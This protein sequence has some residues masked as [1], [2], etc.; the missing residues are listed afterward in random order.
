MAKELNLILIFACI[1][2]ALGMLL[3]SAFSYDLNA[4]VFTSAPLSKVSLIQDKELTL[5]YA[6]E[7][8]EAGTLEK[9]FTNISQ[10]VKIEKIA[11]VGDVNFKIL[12]CADETR[13]LSKCIQFSK[14]NKTCEKT[15]EKSYVVESCAALSDKSAFGL[16]SGERIKIIPDLATAKYQKTL[17]CPSGCYSVFERLYVNGVLIEGA[18]WWSGISMTKYLET[19]TVANG[20]IYTDAYL[21]NQTI[22]GNTFSGNFSLGFLTYFEGS[23]AGGATGYI[24]AVLRYA[25]GTTIITSN[26]NDYTDTGNLERN[27]TFNN[28]VSITTNENYKI[29]VYSSDSTFAIKADT[30]GS[31]FYAGGEAQRG[32]GDWPNNYDVR[33]QVWG[34]V[35]DTTAPAVVFHSAVPADLDSLNGIAGLNLTYN[36]SDAGGINDSS[37]NLTFKSNSSLSDVLSYR[38]GTA[39]LSGWQ[40]LKTHTN[41][42]GQYLFQLGDNQIYPHTEQLSSNWIRSAAHSSVSF[43]GTADYVKMRLFNVSNSSQ[44]GFFELM[45]SNSSATVGSLPFFYCNSSYVSGA[46]SSSAN[47]VS[48]Y[49]LPRTQGYNHSHN[50]SQHVIV[51]FPINATSGTVGGVKVSDVSYFLIRGTAP[52]G[53]NYY[54]VNNFSRTD[55]TQTTGNGGNTWA[56]ETFSLDMHL[57]QYSS[58]YTFYS[59]ACASDVSGNSNCTSARS[60][61]I[62]LGGLPPSA[63]VVYSP[64]TAYYGSGMIINY[65]ASFSPNGYAISYYNISLTD[66]NQTFVST[67]ISNNSDALGYAWTIGATPNGQYIISVRAYDSLGQNSAG[68]SESFTI[69]NVSPVATLG[70][71]PYAGFISNSS[72]VLFDVKGSDNIGLALISV[73]GNWTGA[74]GF[75]ETN[76]T[77]FNNSWW[78][79]TLTGLPDGRWGV[80]AF[81][82]ADNGGTGTSGAYRQFVIDTTA[83]YFLQC[84][85]TG[86]YARNST[87][88]LNLTAFDNIELNTTWIMSNSSGSW[89]IYAM[90]STPFNASLWP[91][92]VSPSAGFIYQFWANDSAG[93]TN[94]S[95]NCSYEIGVVTT[96]IPVTTTTCN[97]TTNGT[98]CCGDC[99]ESGGALWLIFILIFFAV[100]FYVGGKKG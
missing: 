73:F 41:A 65:T 92:S 58:N 44:Y 25:N 45:V 42:S 67:I 94:S 99:S 22:A 39:D 27:F 93:N 80:K 62:G 3:G 1:S 96:T 76:S 40:T 95:A 21:A 63:P 91:V 85:G 34:Y 60:D 19:F 16:K 70:N 7:K 55:D 56:G 89:D 82:T 2:V 69:D 6:P 50:L 77:P 48:F 81:A 36:I 52:Q 97:A 46:V 47:C 13:S 14:D 11:Y 59:Y 23:A 83:P 51:P 29:T 20:Q 72:T 37:V 90:N 26:P 10:L 5:T 61:L 68:Y 57:H 31:N 9:N 35:A 66:L 18:T 54:T 86:V 74:G 79:A 24:Y 17:S 12:K 38:N 33:F 75:G 64:V 32:E 98:C 4:S 28:T 78:N 30:S 84:N 53:W 87:I 43:G 88:F 71:A 100:I 15:D 49:N 8:I